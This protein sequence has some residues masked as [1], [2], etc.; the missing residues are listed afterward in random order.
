MKGRGGRGP[1]ARRP[2]VAGNQ[3]FAIALPAPGVALS[4]ESGG[5]LRTSSGPVA[6][7]RAPV[8]ASARLNAPILSGGRAGSRPGGDPLSLRS[9]LVPSRGWRRRRA[10][11]VAVL[12]FERPGD[13]GPDSGCNGRTVVGG[14]G[15]AVLRSRRVWVL[16]LVGKDGRG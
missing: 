12:A 4:A 8:Y 13:V 16:I 2:G 6:I 15:V 14:L 9:G 1:S 5:R 7:A 11:G 10:G 3:F